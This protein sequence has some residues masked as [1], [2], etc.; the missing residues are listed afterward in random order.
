M[1][2]AGH[3]GVKKEAFRE[4]AIPWQL[5]ATRAMKRRAKGKEEK[6]KAKKRAK[7]A[8]RAKGKRANPRVDPIWAKLEANSKEKERAQT[9]PSYPRLGPAGERFNSRWT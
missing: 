3:H 8:K 7:R 4:L 9:K 6:E 2:G 5:P 1:T